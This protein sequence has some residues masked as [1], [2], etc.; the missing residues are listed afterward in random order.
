MSI[1]KLPNK[2]IH[3]CW[4]GGNPLSELT[5][6]CIETWKKYLPDFEIKEWNENNFDVNQCEFVKQA[7]EQKKWAFVS[8]Y[9]RFKALEEY[10]GLYLDTDMEI[11]ADISKYLENELFLGQ[12]DSKL[13]NAAVVWSKEK[14]N[15]HIKNIVKSYEEK[16]EF[17]ATGDLYKESVPQV[18]SSYFKDFGFDKEKEEI[19]VIDE[20]KVYIYP[21]EYFYPLS[22]DHQHNKFTENSCMIHHFDATWISPMEKFK[23][24][25]KRKNMKWVV[26]IIDFFIAIKRKIAF[27]INFEDVS[28]FLSLFF[29]LLM[30]MFSMKP[31]EFDENI[32]INIFNVKRAV[33]L[34]QITFV[35]FLWTFLCAKIRSIELNF[36]TDKLLKR[37]NLDDEESILQDIP[38]LNLKQTN[39]LHKRE[40][41]LYIIQLIVTLVL[42]L[43]PVTQLAIIVPNSSVWYGIIYIL[44][45]YFFY[46]GL[47][48]KFKYRILELLPYALTLALI[49]FNGNILD[50]LFS[51]FEFFV[52]L[53]YLIKNK[54]KKKRILV[55]SCSFIVFIAFVLL[56]NGLAFEYRNVKSIELN[57]NLLNLNYDN[58]YELY[59]NHENVLTEFNIGKNVFNNNLQ[60]I[61][62][63]LKFLLNYKIYI[64]LSIFFIIILSLINKNKNY[65]SLALF[66]IISYIPKIN[67]NSEVI[68]IIFCFV[69][70]MITLNELFSKILDRKEENI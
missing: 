69:I 57:N 36:Y 59:I 20:N 54:V 17:N 64:C 27:F 11:T 37:S 19:Q 5:K 12:E 22:Y 24:D 1:D 6:K 39:L 3:Y 30:A 34:L 42:A 14:N 10:G 61:F 49:V 35:S 68:Y 33:V 53:F 21:M 55:F 28:I 56:F 52:V 38:Q 62:Y 8:D 16:E 58:D 15:T 67:I 43:F 23:T 66:I 4:F 63:N 26:Y 50:I 41:I 25:M 18:L 2:I 40:K 44:N 13:I 65:L 47:R 60:S 31:I 46:L 51:F 9:A 70:M 32:Y 48:K 29:M 7:Y 45:M